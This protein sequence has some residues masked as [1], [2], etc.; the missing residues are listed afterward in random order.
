MPKIVYKEIAFSDWKMDLIEKANEIV[1]N[2][3]AQGY[4]LTLRQ[5][6]YQFVSR[7]L[8]PD[9]WMDKATGS[10]NNQKSYNNLGDLIG[11]GRMAGIID[12]NSIEDRTRELSRRPHWDNPAEIIES[13]ADSFAID[14][15]EDQKYR[16]EVWVEK[17]ALEG[18]VSKSCKELD[19]NYFSCRG[20]TSQTSMWEAAHRMIKYAKDGKK[21]LVLHLGDHDSSGKDMTRDIQDRLRLFSNQCMDIEV[22][23]IALNMDQIQLYN[24]PPNPAKIT[25]PRAKK[26]I[27]EFGEE[28]W[29]LDALEPSVINEIITDHV[30]SVRDEDLWYE[31]VEEEE[32]GT[33]LLNLTVERWN[34]VVEMLEN[35]E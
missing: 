9:R 24:P 22:R 29:E 18:V 3:K 10:T 6:Y 32:R 25:D 28:S 8:L 2:Y 34:D 20:Y 4:D 19:I 14:K 27:E 21:I 26:Y 7:D 17:D 12:W 33:K 35:E 31:K 16:I 13:A 30:L 1:I 23:R 15:W 11:D 5:L